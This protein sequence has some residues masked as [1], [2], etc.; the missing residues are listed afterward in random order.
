[1]DLR[2]RGVNY[3]VSAR[4]ALKHT[5]TTQPIIML[6]VSLVL[7]VS[8]TM[9][10]DTPVYPIGD[11]NGDR[12]VDL[13]DLGMFVERWLDESCLVPGCE[14][15]LNGTAGVNAIDFG[16]LAENWG[17]D[18][19]RLLISEFMASNGSTP[20]LGEGEL[21]DQDGDS[22]DW[23]EI[24]NPT[25]QA[26]AL[27]GWHLTNDRDDLDKWEFPAGAVIESRD[28]RIVFASNKNPSD[29][30]LRANFELNAG[31]GY[32]ALV[33]EDGKKVISD[34]DYPPQLTDVSYGTSQLAR[35]LVASGDTA[36]YHVPDAIDTE[37]QWIAVTFDDCNW[38]TAKTGLGF[39]KAITNVAD[40]TTPGDVVQGV[41]NDG[42]WP[43]GESPPLAI[44]NNINAKYLHFKGD[45]DPGDPAGGAGFQV[46]PSMGPTIVTGLSFTTANDA[47]ERDPTAFA[48]YGSNTSINGP[49]TLI[50]TGSIVDFGPGTAWPRF[51][52]N[53]TP[54]QFSNDTAY[55]HY[56]LLFPAIRDAA[57]AVAMQIGE[58]ELLGGSAGSATSNI[59]DEMLNINASL[60]MR[61]K[62]ELSADEIG[63]YDALS[64]RMKYQ[65]GF[66]A[67]LNGVEVA[68]RNFSGIPQWNSHADSDRSN[69]SPENFVTIDISNFIH[70][71]TP[72]ANVLAIQALNDT[73]SD[74]NFLIQ[75]ELSAAASVGI[76]Q[77][78][79][80]ATPGKFN[81]TGAVDIV[82]DTQFSVKRGFY[83]APFSVAI[84][85]DTTDATIHYTVDG[86]AP[87]ETSGLTYTGPIQITGT[88]CLRAM[89]FKPGWLST[90]VDTQTYIFL[91]QVIRQPAS[92]PGFPASWGSTPADYAMDQRVVDDSRYSARMRDSLLSIPTLSIVTDVSNLFGL[93]G[94][95][96]NPLMEGP[97]WEHPASIEWINPDGTTGFQINAGLRAYGGAFRR[98]DLTR[99]KTFRLLFKR[100]YGAAKLNFPFFDAPDA[101]T[102]FDTLILRA[103]SN[104]GWNNWGGANTQYIVDEYQRR[105]QLA[106]GQRVGHG[107][108]VHLYVNGLYW[109]LYNPVE[110]PEMSFAATYYGG[111]K[112]EWDSINAGD[113]VGDSQT[114]TWNSMLSQIR[115]GMGSID[116]YQKIQGNNP[117]GTDNPAYD[118]LLDVD[119]Y[120]DYLFSNFWGGTGDWGGRNWYVVCRRPP[121]A[122]GFKFFNWDMEG[123]LIIWSDLNANVI[124]RNE[125]IQ[126]P[127]QA[128]MQNAE[129][130]LLF[131]DH[132]QRHLFNGGPATSGPSWARYKALADE[133]ELAI[134]AE[135][136]RWGDQATGT[137]YTQADWQ[138]KRDYILNEYMPQRPAIVLDQ[139]KAAQ[140][141]P[142]I[143][144]PQF[145]IDGVLQH[146]GYIPDNAVLSMT[147]PGSSGDAIWY[148]TDGADPR[149]GSSGP[150]TS[151]TLIPEA[152]SK[153]VWVARNNTNGTG[154]TGGNE[155]FDDSGWTDGTPIVAGKTG[156]VGLETQ[157]TSSTSYTPYITYDVNSAMYNQYSCAYI[158]I[159]FTVTAEQLADLVTLTLMV[160]YDDGFVAYINGDEVARSSNLG[161][162]G[163]PVAYNARV[164]R[165]GEATA[166]ESFDITAHIGKIHVGNNIL[167]LH[168]VNSANNGSDFIISA[169]L[170]GAKTATVEVT[171]TAIKYNAEQPPMLNLS[172]Q[173]KARAVTAGGEWSALSEATFAVGPVKENLRI[174]ELMYHPSDPNDEFVELFNVGTESINLNLVRFDRGLDLQFAP[175]DVAPGQYIVL[176]SNE[177]KFR[178][179]Y[180]GFTGTIAAEYAG[181]LNNAGETIRL[182]DALGNPIQEFTFKDG[183]YPVT[184]GEG[185]SLTIRDPYNA[186]L[187]QWNSKTGWRPSAMAGGSPGYDDG[188]VLPAPGSI[189]INEVLAHSHAD[190]PDWIELYNTTDNAI[191]IGGWFLSDDAG[192]LNRTKYQI[193]D[194]TVIEGHDYRVFYEDQHFGPTATGPGI[195]NV[196]FSLSEGGEM[197]HLQSATDGVL[198]GYVAMEDFG[199]SAT[200]VSFGRYEK[201]SLSGGYDFV[202][203]A[204]TT[205][206]HANSAPQVGPVLMTEIMYRPGSINTGGE[207]IELHNLTNQPVELQD[208]AS[209]QLSADPLNIGAELVPWRFTDGIEYT[210]PLNTTIPAYGYLIVA[211]N[212]AAF[213]AW[214][215]ALGVGVL[216]PFENG[217]KLSNDGERVTLSRPGDKEWQKDRYY[218]RVDSV[219][220]GDTLPW[221]AAADGT[222]ASL[223]HKNP[224][225]T[226]PS[227]LYGNDPANWSAESPTPGQF[228]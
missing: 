221:P 58:V 63:T 170:T 146:G 130:R 180:P 204:A 46:T 55:T 211:E 198:T 3:F 80:Q 125:A 182:V 73:V 98:M 91:D 144:A 23:I 45:F 99:K 71:L 220:Y 117:D 187:N 131:A 97:A 8:A 105:T 119:N 200:G 157:P 17:E 222:G 174:T 213:N 188:G 176:V 38:K 141:Y 195:R 47:A 87:T 79:R 54:I 84:T 64:L 205:E 210:F 122:T 181:N 26:V 219:E 127:F 39:A 203:M 111:D 217:S 179:L 56:Q 76:R 225:A 4:V 166:P 199:A 160:R 5:N 88:T 218:T 207:F 15:D 68:R 114:A 224:A 206:D 223:Q 44:D 96:E 197:V 226:D 29:T 27:G 140:L 193:E 178:Q 24:Y 215:G 92:P 77:Y 95:Y 136:A 190:A 150:A 52:K 169:E 7:V 28:F 60:W 78:F 135:S 143:E 2:S 212:P 110:R 192:E 82:Q 138:V 40:V 107:R 75:P 33:E 101:T 116:A 120:I 66:V 32:L 115:Q 43:G 34:Y 183:W 161:T 53:T 89:A 164:S 41:P 202:L 152:A 93:T 168:G 109:G 171:P 156:G 25:R 112:A 1:M 148:T 57:S 100:E 85:T 227:R 149:K 196:P 126:E 42:D 121:N 133:V 158:R 13:I 31:G 134:I 81:G 6:A 167:A 208:L 102:S 191:H 20:P 22:S 74:E 162:A 36:A 172:W 137:P 108:F 9:F 154:W 83:D 37:A 145:R 70:R 50:A 132:V 165:S 67:Y 201:A 103:G 175:I 142:Q 90:N 153:K 113:P 184:D 21:L 123:A 62:F 189:V 11:L 118:D 65:D 12:K 163:T 61:L 104:D 86:S 106:L 51:T 16:I 151:V 18:W 228:E 147:V 185:F 19:G 214:Y 69:D 155:P 139:L 177:L 14:A 59:R 10:A 35:T 128:L 216:G 173:V 30:E 129:F 209:T 159:P 186:D 124:G 194:G 49:Y 72:G 48:L 94:I